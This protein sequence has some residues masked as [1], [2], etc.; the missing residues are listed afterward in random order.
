[1]NKS[2]RVKLSKMNKEK[3]IEIIEF[4]CD[5]KAA[6][7]KLSLLVNSSSADI[8]KALNEFDGLCERYRD[9]PDSESIANRLYA[10]ANSLFAVADKVAAVPE[11][12]IYC[13]VIDTYQTNDIDELC[14]DWLNDY[15]LNAVEGLA[16]L[17]KNTE[18]ELPPDK[19]EEYKQVVDYYSE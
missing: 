6:E 7:K 17:L 1:M 15:L 16:L 3:L 13:G 12:Q 9:N 14:D 8:D 5:D 4:L 10:A 11:A 2:I 18:N 19:V